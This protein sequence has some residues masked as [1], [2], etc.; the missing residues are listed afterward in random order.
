MTLTDFS[1]DDDLKDYSAMI[2]VGLIFLSAA[3]NLLYVVYKIWHI[4]RAKVRLF[5]RKMYKKYG[6]K[7]VPIEEK[8]KLYPLNG[9]PECYTFDGTVPSTIEA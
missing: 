7:F 9:G 4:I 1:E 6:P 8:N 3:V 2:L 5:C